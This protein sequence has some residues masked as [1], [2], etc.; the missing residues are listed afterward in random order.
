MDSGSYSNPNNYTRSV[1]MPGCRNGARLCAV[2]AT[3]RLVMTGCP[4]VEMPGINPL[5]ISN[6]LQSYIASGLVQLVPTPQPPP[7]D[8][9]YVFFKS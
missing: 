2:F 3:D 8:T 6:N 9:A 4:P 7:P 1:V 5:L